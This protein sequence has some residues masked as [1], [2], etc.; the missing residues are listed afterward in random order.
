MH[1]PSGVKLLHIP[2]AEGLPIPLMELT[3]L[4]ELLAQI[5]YFPASPNIFTF[6]K[7]FIDNLNKSYL[8]NG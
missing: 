4:L 2:G 5:S 7:V 6:S 3:R 8:N 1:L